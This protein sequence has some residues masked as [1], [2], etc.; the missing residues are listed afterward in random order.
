MSKIY[1]QLSRVYD[2]GWGDFSRQYVS[3][4]ENLL[5]ERDISQAKILDLKGST[6]YLLQSRRVGFCLC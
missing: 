2:L 1:T 4:I 6:E 3:L 5:K